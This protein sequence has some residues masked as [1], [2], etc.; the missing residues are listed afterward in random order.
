MRR[1]RDVAGTPAPRGDRVCAALLRLPEIVAFVDGGA[2]ALGGDAGDGGD[3]GEVGI[4]AGV[5]VEP[6]SIRFEAKGVFR[7][8]EVVP[9][10]GRCEVQ[11]L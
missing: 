11:V 3:V 6:E 4:L 7:C 2:E 5:C 10:A 9:A 1:E 8:V